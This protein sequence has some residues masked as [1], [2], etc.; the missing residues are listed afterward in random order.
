VLCFDISFFLRFFIGI[1]F[2][3]YLMQRV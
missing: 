2:V 1:P 3:M